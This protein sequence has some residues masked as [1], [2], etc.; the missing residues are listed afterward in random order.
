V[1]NYLKVAA[2]ILMTL[3]LGIPTFV[4]NLFDAPGKFH[5]WIIRKWSQL[6][7]WVSG[8]RVEL[9]GAENLQAANPAVIII[10]HESALD[11]PLVIG[12]L[13]VPVRFMA[14]KELF[15]VPIIGWELILGGHIRIDRAR[16][17][18]AIRSIA[19]YAPAIFREKQNIVVSPE[20]TRSRD[21]K[22]GP[23]KKGGFVLA[24]DFDVPLIPV[25]ILGS[26][27]RV[28]NR[29]YRICTG[30]V[31]LRIDPAVRVSDFADRETCIRAI[32]D[33]MIRHRD[34]YYAQQ[35][36]ELC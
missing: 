4:I 16:S 35:K 30:T 1:K 5:S 7:L 29:S 18:R 11:I 2:I 31:R 8:I 12:G 25:T 20:G 21:G 36:E 19:T 22:M 34:E 14:K 27:D 9:Q 33:Q 24:Q 17:E 26:R 28:P 6:L 32:R 15:R 23:F 13:P 3:V 10:N